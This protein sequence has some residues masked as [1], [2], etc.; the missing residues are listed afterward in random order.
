MEKI[1]RVQGVAVLTKQ[2]Y[3]LGPNGGAVLLEPGEYPFTIMDGDT[4]IMTLRDP[5]DPKVLIARLPRE[6]AA[7]VRS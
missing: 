6:Y 5:E 7:Q 3:G 2:T 4:D 1:G